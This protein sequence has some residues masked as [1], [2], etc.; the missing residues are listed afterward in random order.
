MS[1]DEGVQKVKCKGGRATERVHMIE[2]RFM[3]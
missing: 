1:A 3:Q 2:C